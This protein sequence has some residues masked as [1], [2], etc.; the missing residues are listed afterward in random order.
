MP[1]SRATSPYWMHCS[2]KFQRSGKL[3]EIPFSLIKQKL[4]SFHNLSFAV[5]YR[6]CIWKRWAN[7]NKRIHTT[8]SQHCTRNCSQ[9]IR[10]KISHNMIISTAMRC[11]LIATLASAT[12]NAYQHRIQSIECTSTI[13]Y[14][15]I[16]SSF[17]INNEQ[18]CNLHKIHS[19]NQNIRKEKKCKTNCNRRL[20]GVKEIL[21]S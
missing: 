15:A 14:F 6:L 2:P 12:C 4:I 10:N 11:L 17:W 21:F 1:R 9:L 8:Y 7:L 20:F 16:R 5:S 3:I 19:I 13:L 18:N